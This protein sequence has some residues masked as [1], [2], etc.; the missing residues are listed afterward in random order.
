MLE[1]TVECMK[2]EKKRKEDIKELKLKTEEDF[3]KEVVEFKYAN[4]LL[5][6]QLEIA[7]KENEILKKTLQQVKDKKINYVIKIQ[8]I[9]EKNE[10][11]KE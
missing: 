11:E 5:T 7:S 10:N 1:K 9:K 8:E 3:I 2:N 4:V 6:D